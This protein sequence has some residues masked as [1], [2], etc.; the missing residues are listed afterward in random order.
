MESLPENR[1]LVWSLAVSLL[2]IVGLLL[3]SS[4]DFNSQFGLVDIPVE[5]SGPVGMALGLILGPNL[6]APRSP[7]LPALQFK[8]IIAQ[9]LILDFCLA[10]LADR[11]LQFFLGT[12]KLKVPS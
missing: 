8:L 7:S 6:W 4:P 1:P 5:V 2:A 11:V 12:P 9:V 3:G 10:L